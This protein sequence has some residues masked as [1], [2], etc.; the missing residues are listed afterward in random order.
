MFPQPDAFTP[1]LPAAPLS[2]GAQS[3]PGEQIAPAAQ[4]S[5]V[6]PLLPAAPA[7]PAAPGQAAAAIARPRIN[8]NITAPSSIRMNDRFNIN[9][10]A[11]NATDLTNALF[12]LSFDPALLDYDGASEGA[13]LKMD[14][15]QTSFQ[16]TGIKNSG[17]V[18]VNLRRTGNTGGVTGSGVLAVLSFKA[19]SPGTA[20]L[21]FQ[22]SELTDSGGKSL[23]VI[24]FKAFVEVK[25]PEMTPSAP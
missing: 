16:A 1:A 4:T 5:V 14:G 25:Q 10:V 17:Q 12:V 24:P 15:K 6:A 13:F 3:A 8:L 2:P 23:S 7:L 9:I 22:S 18:S 20:G 19:K 21:G 11:S